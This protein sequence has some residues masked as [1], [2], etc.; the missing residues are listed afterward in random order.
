MVAGMER[1]IAALGSRYDAN[2]RV[3]FIELGLL[4]FWG[5][6]HTWPQETLYAS[7]ETE[8]RVIE[9]YRR[10]FPHK[11]L[12]ARYARDYAGSKP[13]LGFHD[14]LLPEDTDNGQDW[15]FLAGLRRSGRADNWKLA[16]IGGEM[17]P[18]QAKRWLGEGFKTT[19]DT[20]ERGHFTCVGPY[21]P[22]LDASNSREFRKRA[23]AL[24]R[25]MAYQFR[26]TEVRHA[27]SIAQGGTL[28]VTIRAE[29]EGVAPLYYP[30]PVELAL[31]D[32]KGKIAERLPLRSDVRSWQPG[33][34]AVDEQVGIKARPGHYKLA[35]GILDPWTGRLALTFATRIPRHEGW[36]VISSV[37]IGQDR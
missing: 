19:L 2:P 11:I 32:E 26:L 27:G 10:A 20:I 6:W 4:G 36:A 1:L 21:C 15:S 29:N 34:F 28:H 35:M 22:A 14:D 23:E 25:R 33:P 9:A 8:R 5:E 12:Q 24:V 18:L 37:E 16:A 7:K 13:W 3:A 30:W 17:V 31:I